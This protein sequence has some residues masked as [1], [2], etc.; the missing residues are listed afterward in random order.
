MKLYK[1]AVILLILIFAVSGHA[2]KKLAQTGFQFLSVGQDA[3]A[4]AMG[5]AFTTM[6]GMSNALF[7]NPAGISR[8]NSTLDITA[9]YFSW[10]AGIKH[11]SVSAAYSL[12]NGQYG[13]IG[14]SVQSIDY[15]DIEG[16]M[17]WENTPGYIETGTF[18]PSAIAIGLAYGRSLTDKFV[19]GGQVKFVSQYLGRSALPN[20]ITQRNVADAFAFDFG[21]IYHTGFRSLRFGM[22]V[23][24]FSEE[25]K[26]EEE[27]FQLPLTFK[28]GLSANAF[29]YFLTNLREQSLLL[30]FDAVHPRSYPEYI[31]VGAEYHVL[32]QVAVRFGYVTNQDEYDYSVGL[33]FKTL[34]AHFDYSYMPFGVFNDIHRFSL[35]L[36]Y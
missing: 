24:N 27:G 22:S 12:M 6:E 18:S 2:Q 7:Y 35:H 34:G 28:I 8:L 3:R 9:N 13:V 10:M 36:S 32:E 14:L 17:V 16:T 11:M 31:N 25:I 33:G 26:F 21:T 29:D 30:V 20:G 23:R 5:G 15:G 1:S 4:T 19:I